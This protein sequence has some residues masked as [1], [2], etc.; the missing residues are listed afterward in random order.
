VRN[1]VNLCSW[2]FGISVY[3]EISLTCNICPFPT[4]RSVCLSFNY[5]SHIQFSALY[6]Y[7]RVE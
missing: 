6:V 4:S 2:G 1:K 3:E 5:L 7:F